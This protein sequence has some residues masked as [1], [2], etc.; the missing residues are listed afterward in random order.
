MALQALSWGGPGLELGL[1]PR[2]LG[3]AGLPHSAC[4]LTTPA[5]GGQ[6]KGKER[7]VGLGPFGVQEQL[8]KGL[9][10]GECWALGRGPPCFPDSPPGGC[11][12]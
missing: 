12:L 11:L 1:C 4:P 10:P 9:G 6:G 8:G 2:P 3:L 7:Q 5:G